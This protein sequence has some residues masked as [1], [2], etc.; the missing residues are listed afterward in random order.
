MGN[1][2]GKTTISR[3]C[4][5]TL[6]RNPK[7]ITEMKTAFSPKEQGIYTHVRIEFVRPQQASPSTTL[8][9]IINQAQGEKYVFGV[10]GYRDSTLKYYCYPGRLEDVPIV[11]KDSQG[12]FSFVQNEDFQAALKKTSHYKWDVSSE[13]WKER[14]HE[15]WGPQQLQ[16]MVKYMQDGGDDKAASLYK[17]PNIRTETFD[18][19]FFYTHIAPYLT[20]GSMGSYQADDNDDPSLEGK[21]L[22]NAL[23]IINTQHEGQKK[24]ASLR[25]QDEVLKIF[26]KIGVCNTRIKSAEKD[27]SL[28]VGVISETAG[29]I[30][31]LIQ[32][33]PLPGIP[34]P[35]STGSPRLNEFIKNIIILPHSPEPFAVKDSGLALL[36]GKDT[37]VLNLEAKQHGITP[38]IETNS[39]DTCCPT[40]PKA[41]RT[42]C[43]KEAQAIAL[44]NAVITTD[45][46]ADCDF[47]EDIIRDGF[48]FF[49]AN[50]DTSPI[51]LLLNK[52]QHLLDELDTKITIFTYKLKK[53]K[54]KLD[55]HEEALKTFKVDKNAYNEMLT[56]GLFSEKELKG[57]ED[58]QKQLKSQ[59]EV[60]QQQFTE[61]TAIVSANQKEYSLCETY[62]REHPNN[63]PSEDLSEI[64]RLQGKHKQLEKTAS[65]LHAETIQQ[66]KRSRPSL[67]KIEKKLKETEGAFA[68]FEKVVDDY[69]L[70]T[71]TFP[72]DNLV[73]FCDK[74][75]EKEVALI[76]SVTKNRTELSVATQGYQFECDFFKKFGAPDPSRWLEDVDRERKVLT[77]AEN[78]KDARLTQTG[79]ELHFLEK[80]KVAPGKNAK[81]ALNLIPSSIQY[82]PLYSF[83]KDKFANDAQELLPLF[84]SFLFAPVIED[85]CDID[86]VIALYNDHQDDILL[87]VFH[88][89]TLSVFLN[90][91]KGHHLIHD[92]VSCY[93][94]SGKETGTI[95]AI[96][97]PEDTEAQ[98][99]ALKREISI[100]E[101]DL[102]DISGKLKELKGNSP[103]IILANK[104]QQ[105]VE[106]QLKLKTQRLNKSLLSDEEA[107]KKHKTT[108]TQKT[109]ASIHKAATFLTLGGQTIYDRLHHNK[110][111]LVKRVEQ[112]T[113]ELEELET[114]E[115]KELE[116]CKS[117]RNNI[118]EYN[119]QIAHTKQT[120]VS[121]CAFIKAD[122]MSI[123]TKAKGDAEK[124]KN[125]L[126]RT[127]KKLF[128]EFGRAASY[129]TQ[130]KI[131][132]ESAREE[133]FQE[134]KNNITKYEQDIDAEQAKLPELK[135]EI[136]QFK[137]KSEK[138]DLFLSALSN[139]DNK[140]GMALQEIQIDNAPKIP[141]ELQALPSLLE[142]TLTRDPLSSNIEIIT[143]DTE[144]YFEQRN[145]DLLLNKQQTALLELERT[146]SDF[147]Q[148]CNKEYN[149]TS[150]S[151]PLNDAEKEFIIE[152]METPE[153]L[154]LFQQNLT[155][156]Q[157]KGKMEYERGKEDEERLRA[158]LATSLATLAANAGRNLKT[159]RKAMD[160]Q[161]E[162]GAS[163][164]IRASVAS[165]EE[166]TMAINN[167]INYIK[168]IHSKHLQLKET[169]DSG[170]TKAAEAKHHRD[171]K[172]DINE[173]CY[174]SIFRNP[175]VKHIHPFIRG[176]NATPL[177]LREKG[178]L[179]GGER[180]SLS[181]M[182]QVRMAQYSHLRKIQEDRALGV[183]RRPNASEG[184]NILWIDG[185][186]SN[187]SS[188][189]LIEEAF[190]CIKA[191]HGSFQIIGLIHNPAYI[192]TH[193]FSVFPNLYIGRTHTSPTAP[194]SSD[195]WVSLDKRDELKHKTLGFAQFIY[196]DKEEAHV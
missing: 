61:N 159:L 31:F 74:V 34:T 88:Q 24:E 128:F 83:I 144:R 151:T 68:E 80:Q 73:G 6:S 107:L 12:A 28:A 130:S 37:V 58:T 153:N 39:I 27:L 75:R 121:I 138:Y 78:E 2:S 8:P 181:L 167:L 145:I 45:T 173:K 183:R 23:S 177:D 76:T 166:I 116:A 43:Y 91:S 102:L 1:G 126:D 15:H 160:Q 163:F 42:T 196:K 18:T 40:V 133:A 194:N 189:S 119:T 113:S 114:K 29:S 10:C 46:H 52:K 193:D 51:R 72:D 125:S 85:I 94:F 17:V 152:I 59:Q 179:S 4:L 56:S 66:L 169:L 187:L 149:K 62:F 87:P 175:S 140:L 186:F 82:V 106:Q 150:D 67:K 81:K 53:E 135:A 142:T 65:T 129:V 180:T 105:S 174:R 69:T 127:I 19:T 99:L 63:V 168:T 22:S 35:P 44:I 158:S 195:S 156:A 131:N 188:S 161:E 95:K 178:R 143:Y 155:K 146:K 79:E 41:A 84:S 165:F 176:G 64:E 112:L 109:I 38:S 115:V 36:L 90:K 103:D 157:T 190:R 185:L 47:N 134:L 191:T 170:H 139:I 21:I 20:I 148:I 184:Q 154:I 117:A 100:L 33:S 57:P 60:L 7:L 172:A 111:D 132:S 48:I 164:N 97:H 96:I 55:E 101:Q 77:L 32:D 141:D 25:R 11:E 70:I 137:N 182:M 120:L 5:G 26:H 13:D 147:N 54:A 86:Q 123:Y 14:I 171:L 16:Q 92:G 110:V 162:G 118:D 104:A 98:K 49:K 93:V 122:K 136:K 9:G 3:S 192:D 71:S 50:C 30:K 89:E 124:Y 108:Y